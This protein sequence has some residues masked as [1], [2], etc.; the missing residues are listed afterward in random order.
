MKFGSIIYPI[1]LL[2]L[3]PKY[4]N[5]ES[6]TSIQILSVGSYA[7]NTRPTLIVS[8]S[9]PINDKFAPSASIL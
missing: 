9:K 4:F 2:P 6:I 1:P 5:I 8:T 3:Q 7:N